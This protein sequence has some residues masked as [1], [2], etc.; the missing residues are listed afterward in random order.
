MIPFLHQQKFLNPPP[1]T[2]ALS[3]VEHYLSYHTRLLLPHV[4]SLK[5][6]HRIA[7]I[8]SLLSAVSAGFITL[9]SLYS[10][11]WQNHLNYSSWQINTI[12]SMTNL[13]M[14][15]TPPILGMIADSHGPITLSLL[16]IIG[17]YPAIRIWRMFSIIQNY[18]LRGTVTH[19]SIC[20]Y[21]V[22]PS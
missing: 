19:R 11:P 20:Q 17:L 16:S 8:F 15:L 3:K 10:Q 4:L 5:S 9:I 1:P 18:P 13:G 21:C 7:Y 14:Y 22:S 2:M 12:A 6:S